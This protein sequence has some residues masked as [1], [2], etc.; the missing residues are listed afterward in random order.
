MRASSRFCFRGYFNGC[1]KTV[2]V[3]IQG[4]I[5]AF[6][7]RIP[8]SY[9]VS[10]MANATLFHIGLATPA[11]SLVQTALC[12]GYFLLQNQRQAR[13]AREKD[14]LSPQAG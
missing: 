2:F 9:M 3:M 12:V 14:K 1:G 8:I 13:L 5:G 11:S 10:R 4:I 6:G 7:V